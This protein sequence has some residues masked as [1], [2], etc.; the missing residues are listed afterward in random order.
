MAVKRIVFDHHLTLIGPNTSLQGVFQGPIWYYLLSIPTFL[1]NGDPW[2]SVILMLIISMSV[3]LVS[4]FWIKK[5]FGYK[6]AITTLFLL[7]ISPQA[8]A[9]ATF[10]WNPHPMW[11][12]LCLFI[13]SFYELNQGKKKFHLPVWILIALM[14]HFE[15]ALGFFIFLSTVVYLLLFNRR[16]LKSKYFFFGI[17]F[18]IILLLP[19]II[20]EL[21]HNFLMISSFAKTLHGE[22]QGLIS[23]QE[24]SSYFVYT[25]GHFDNFQLNF[26]YAF[27][28]EGVLEKIPLIFFL[29]ILFSFLF[30]KKFKIFSA[31]E[32]KFL[33]LNVKFIIILFIL[34]IFYPFPIRYWFLTGLEIFYILITGLILSKL[35]LNRLSAAVL[36]LFFIANL[37]IFIPRIYNLHSKPD[38]GSTS[39]VKGKTNA[40]EYIYKDANGKPFNLL[41][42]TPSVYTDP[43]DYLTFISSKNKYHYLP[44]TK[45]EG[46]F[47]LLIDPDYSKPWSYVGWLETVIKSGKIIYTKNLP[48]GFILQKRENI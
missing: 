20:F 45:K 33:S 48:G 2:G 39:K 36:Y 43:Y 11:L 23:N 5:L 12:I 17:I 28:H 21:R 19:Q 1:M 18:F 47:Y 16:V 24:K 40:I 46:S 15:I 29:F 14:S 32:H 31:N 8:V 26:D 6:A 42:F 30:G 34:F 41:V 3:M 9:A 4:F 27:F 7:A 22:N 35:M 37:I 38:Y 13:F 25:K 10:S 44:G